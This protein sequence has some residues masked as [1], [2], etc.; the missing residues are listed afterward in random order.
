MW[1]RNYLPFWVICVHTNWWRG[2]R[3]SFFLYSVSSF[4][5]CIVFYN[6]SFA[7]TNFSFT[8]IP[9]SRCGIIQPLWSP[10]PC[11]IFVLYRIHSRRRQNTKFVLSRKSNIG[12]MLFWKVCL[13][14]GFWMPANICLCKYYI[15][16]L[17]DQSF[18]YWRKLC[19][20]DWR[21]TSVSIS[22]MCQSL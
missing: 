21:A 19:R 2:S 16:L 18:F 7:S 12:T 9:S 14:I 15:P 20:W 17:N 4:G 8:Y 5:P 11:F 10:E 1:S 3:C 6:T 13:S 22:N